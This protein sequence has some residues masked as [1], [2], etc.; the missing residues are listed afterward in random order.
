MFSFLWSLKSLVMSN[1]EESEK[2]VEAPIQLEE[3]CKVLAQI[4]A[5]DVEEEKLIEEVRHLDAF[6]RSNLF[7]QKKS[8]T[9][10][11]LLNGIY[12]KGLQPLFESV[13]I[14]LRIF[15]TIPVS[16]AEGEKS[17]SKLALVKTALRSTMSQ[18]RLTNLLIISIEHDLA[19]KLCYGEVI[20]KFAMSKARKINFL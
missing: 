14:V 7:G 10:M 3:K 13:C 9:S 15:N 8:L 6:K 19:K 4:Y 5:T 2:S 17:F 20:S 18:E 1:E 16:V 11:T 12:Q